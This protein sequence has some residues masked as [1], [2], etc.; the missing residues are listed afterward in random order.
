MNK[1]D[2]SSLT[3]TDRFNLYL[4]DPAITRELMQIKRPTLNVENVPSGSG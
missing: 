2:H 4:S 3:L 1:D